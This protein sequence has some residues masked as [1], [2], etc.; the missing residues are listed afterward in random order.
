[1]AQWLEEHKALRVVCIDLEGEGSFA[2]VLIVASANSVRHAQS[3]ADGVALLCRENNYEF[4]RTEGYAT[5]Q[6]ILVDMNDIIVN[7]FQESVRELYALEA[8]W[9]HGSSKGT[10]AGQDSGE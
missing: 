7:V 2:D 8:L 4:L 10:A 5:G 3:L 1:M 6:W 9:G